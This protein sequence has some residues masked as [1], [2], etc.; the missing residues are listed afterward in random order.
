[1]SERAQ[2]RGS[3]ATGRARRMLSIGGLGT[4]VGG[5]YLW[6]L[7]SRPFRP[8]DRREKALIEAHLRNA[9]RIVDRS[10]ELRG[11]FMKLVQM[12]S[13]RA[14]LFPPEVL[15]VLSTVQSAVPPMPYEL[16]RAQIEQELGAA[17]ERLFRSFEKEAFAAASLG[18]VHRAVLPGGQ[19]VAVK[20]QYPG[21]EA[22]VSQD[23]ANVR[24]LLRVLARVAREVTRRPVDVREV[25][26]ELEA[27]LS[28]ELDYR[29]EAE[30]VQR[31][32]QLLADD[33]EVIIP[34]V[35]PS[36][37]SRRVLTLELIEG[38]PIMEVLAPGVDAELRDWVAI[39]YFRLVWRQLFEFGLVHT[40]PH[41]GNYLV[42]YH[43]RLAILDFG[44]VREFPEPIRA[45]YLEL[46]RAVV[47]RDRERM[48]DA[49]VALGFLG[50]EDD[51]DPLVRA[52]ELIVE[53]VLEDR[54]YDP[55][56]YPIVERGLQVAAIALEHGLFRTP[57]HRVFLE[58]ALLGLDAYMAR[59]G[60]VSNWHRIFRECVEAASRARAAGADRQPPP[61]RPR[62]QQRARRGG[63]RHEAER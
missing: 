26:E 57:G 63:G 10:A 58:R 15:A 1:M 51:P 55:R 22:T 21:V 12:L 41:P 17:P 38:Y 5:S 60:T 27:R 32:R 62:R 39:K 11:A 50:A 48:R 36:R 43:P 34:R 49:A 19:R 20:V 45:A 30:S 54:P 40:D 46:A 29:R 14:D 6:Q 3:L 16:I 44:S 47:D 25:T 8:A 35:Y 37:S 53:P 7:L 61:P 13:M 59:A 42:T 31:F 52:I 4:A 24:S 56:S 18:Q 2:P 33:P 23:L 9:M 28:E